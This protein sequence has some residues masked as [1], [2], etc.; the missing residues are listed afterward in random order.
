MKIGLIGLSAK[1][2]HIGHHCIIDQA[3]KDN[4]KVIVFVSLSDRKRKGE[5]T[6]LGTDMR[7]IWHHHIKELMPANCELVFGGSPI[8]QIYSFLGEANEKFS[9]D[10]YWIYGDPNDIAQNFPETALNKYANVL[11]NNGQLFLSAMPRST[12]VDISGTQMREFLMWGDKVSFLSY[13]PRGMDGDAVWDI[14][15]DSLYAKYPK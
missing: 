15:Y 8:R 6:I 7:K 5:P 10:E 13:L 1:P 3:S 12:T 9:E 11:Y 2:Y 4:D 14:L